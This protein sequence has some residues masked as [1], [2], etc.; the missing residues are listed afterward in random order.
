MRFTSIKKSCYSWPVTL[1]SAMAMLLL[2]AQ[3]F[4]LVYGQE[5]PTVDPG[6][7]RPDAASRP[8]VRIKDITHVQ[9]VRD[10][11][12]VGLGL[13]VGLDGTGDSSSSQASIQMVSNMLQQ[14]GVEV[15]SRYFRLRNAAAVMVTATLPAFARAGATIDA[16]IASIGDARS[17]QGGLLLQTP[18]QAA[19]GEVYAVAQGPLTI[20]GQSAAAGRAP[21]TH[22]LTALIPAG[23]IV[24]REVSTN[25]V[26]GDQLLLVLNS[27]DFATASRVAQ[28]VNAAVGTQTATA[29]DRSAI[30]VVLPPPEEQNPVDFL[31]AL[32]ELPVT[33]DAPARVVVNER[34]GTVIIG[35]GV[36]IAPVAV[37]HGNLSV[38]IAPP[39]GTEAPAYGDV[40][41]TESHTMFL[42]GSSV[43]DVVKGLNAIGATPKDIIALLQAIRAAGALYGELVGI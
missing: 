7:V 12:L 18:L 5:A 8:V 30:Q 27:P 33:P 2:I 11:Q 21:R 37:T 40:G 1:A 36:R 29:L 14:F 13:V 24:E 10:N 42:P 39:G 31:A 38:R 34:T 3:P 22:S 15:D 23:A 25:F 28:A 19:N 9:G 6:W 20:G 26:Q 32:E 41:G 35:A 17:L 16:T 43:E 4:S